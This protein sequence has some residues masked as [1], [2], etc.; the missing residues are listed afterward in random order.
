LARAFLTAGDR[1][2]KAVKSH[3]DSTAIA[4]GTQ[5]RLRLLRMRRANADSRNRARSILEIENRVGETLRK[6]TV[7]TAG[8]E[9]AVVQRK[10]LVVVCFHELS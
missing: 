10:K 7:R 8:S 1:F 2:G 5:N 9:D 6:T 3:Q 4:I